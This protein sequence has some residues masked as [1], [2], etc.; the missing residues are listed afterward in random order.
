MKRRLRF[1]SL[2]RISRRRCDS[3]SIRNSFQ[4]LED[5]VWSTKKLLGCQ[6]HKFLHFS[7]RGQPEAMGHERTPIDI[8]IPRWRVCQSLLFRI[9]HSLQSKT[10]PR[11]VCLLISE[12]WGGKI[13]PAISRL[14]NIIWAL[15]K[16]APFC[17]VIR[18]LLFPY[19]CCARKVDYQ[20]HKHYLTMCTDILHHCKFAHRLAYTAVQAI[21]QPPSTDW[22]FSSRGPCE[23]TTGVVSPDVDLLGSHRLTMPLLLIDRHGL[24]MLYRLDA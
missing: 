2:P 20:L 12:C 4:R 9:A 22:F 3:K 17:P 7:W 21:T 23:E 1:W 5:V 19:G 8:A 15:C 6:L 24:E 14:P 13:L 11:L 10:S 16:L 18:V